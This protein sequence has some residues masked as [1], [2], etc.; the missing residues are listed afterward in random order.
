MIATDKWQSKSDI[1]EKHSVMASQLSPPSITCATLSIATPSSTVGMLS[2]NGLYNRYYSQSFASSKS[3][4]FTNA[5]TAE[6]VAFNI[7]GIKV[8]QEKNNFSLKEVH[9]YKYYKLLH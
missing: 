9:G 6:G 3:K 8:S 4:L 7:S 1:K 5:M 2:A